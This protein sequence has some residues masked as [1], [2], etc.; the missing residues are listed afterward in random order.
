M[1]AGVLAPPF[2]AGNGLHGEGS[3]PLPQLGDRTRDTQSRGTDLIC[4][5]GLTLMALHGVD[6]DYPSG[7]LDGSL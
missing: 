2:A 5:E 1:W 7:P 4:L 6:P 3:A